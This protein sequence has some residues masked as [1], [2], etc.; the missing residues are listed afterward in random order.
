MAK[1]NV[2]STDGSVKESLELKDEVFG[3]EPSEASVHAVVVMQLANKRQGTH[4]TLTR[5]E[6][7]GGGK[8]PWRQK[9]TGRARVGSS[10][11]PVWRKG[12]VA[13]GPK[14]RDYSYSLPKKVKRLA[15]KSVL[16]DKVANEELIVVDSFNFKEP[17]TKEMKNVLAN[18]KAG[19]TALIVTLDKENN[20]IASASNLQ[21]VTTTFT[22]SVNVYDMVRHAS[23]IA[24]KEAV[25]KLE[26]VLLDA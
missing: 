4:S 18:L 24:T 26:E 3:I 5:A 10:R 17:K 13:F 7:S 25:L 1:I 6:V 14:P 15:M 8:K 11:N 16:S 22:G 20:V 23:L 19:R 12:G 2:L 9:G 21:G